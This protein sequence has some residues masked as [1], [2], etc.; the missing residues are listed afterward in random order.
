MEL[1]M[2]KQIALGVVLTAGFAGSALAAEGFS[3]SNVEASYVSLNGKGGAADAD[4]FGIA[5]SY[6]FNENFSVFAAYDDADFDGAEG[7]GGSLK[8]LS[9]GLG[10]HWGLSDNL[11]L[12]SGLSYESV[13]TG[14][15]A[16]G[17]GAALGLR[18]RLGESFELTGGVKYTDL[19]K[20][21]KAQTTF[22]VG[23]RY[24]FTPA[25][26]LGADFS[27]ED[28]L[29]KAWRVSLRYDFGNQ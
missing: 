18:G 24:Y 10:F 14:P 1:R 16:S 29:G 22:S 23:G 20:G 17:Y 4:G 13:D 2:R 11:D 19:N 7:G 21:W 15:N 5:G 8:H 28:D 25:F 9:L 3:Y 6:G 12:T 26:A 27:D